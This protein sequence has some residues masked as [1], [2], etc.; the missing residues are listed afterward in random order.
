MQN[1]KKN[2]LRNI[3]NKQEFSNGIA[4][5]NIKSRRHNVVFIQS[6]KN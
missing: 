5:C 4:N 2:K 1:I 3:I 6:L